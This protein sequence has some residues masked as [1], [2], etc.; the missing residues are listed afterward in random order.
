[1]DLSREGN[2]PSWAARFTHEQKAHL[3]PAVLPVPLFSPPPTLSKASL[4]PTAVSGLED[5][6]LGGLLSE[7]V[8]CCLSM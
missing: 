1:M 2:F 5:S 4:T 8:R 3:P 6:I 7:Q